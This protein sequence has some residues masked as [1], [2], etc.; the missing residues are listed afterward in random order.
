MCALAATGYV[1]PANLDSAA[2]QELI[3]PPIARYLAEP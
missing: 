1:T 2:T 3:H